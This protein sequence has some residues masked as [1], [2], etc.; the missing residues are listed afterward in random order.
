MTELLVWSLL[1]G[2]GL[3]D[4]LKNALRAHA[5]DTYNHL[6]L[7]DEYDQVD[8][9]TG[10]RGSTSAANADDIDIEEGG[11]TEEYQIDNAT[12]SEE[13]GTSVPLMHLVKHLIQNTTCQTQMLINA[14][15]NGNSSKTDDSKVHDTVSPSCDLLLRFQSCTI[16]GRVVSELSAWVCTCAARST[17]SLMECVS[18]LT[19][20]ARACDEAAFSLPAAARHETDTLGWPGLI[21]RRHHR[22][23]TVIRKCDIQN[24]VKDGGSWIVVSGF[25]YDVEKFRCDSTSTVDLVRKLRGS[26]ATAALSEEPHAAYLSAITEKC[27]GLYAEQVHGHHCQESIPTLRVLHMLSS[28]AFQLMLGMSECGVRLARSLPVQQAERK[29]SAHAAAVFLRGGLQVPQLSNPFE[30]EKAEARSGSS[31][32]GNSPA[33]EVPAPRPFGPAPRPSITTAH[34]RADA[35]LYALAEPKLLVRY[36]RFC[37]LQS[38]PVLTL[39]APCA[40]YL[41]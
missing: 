11:C 16:L 35:L 9:V 38:L 33:G 41:L 26:D 29:V 23:M 12:T 40:R 36:P 10:Q 14:I 25:V 21:T 4:A 39:P 1:G 19:V 3:R 7:D 28:T 24:H 20:V 8:I 6:Q 27:V 34:A 2:G 18:S 31:T 5:T 15:I 13:N 30:E 17:F 32:G 37:T 22:N